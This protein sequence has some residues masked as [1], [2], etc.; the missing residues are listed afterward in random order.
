MPCRVWSEGRY[1]WNVLAPERSLGLARDLLGASTCTGSGRSWRSVGDPATS[2]RTSNRCQDSFCRPKRARVCLRS[3]APR[4]RA[5]LAPDLRIDAVS[6][7]RALFEVYLG[8]NSVVPDARAAW[9]QGARALLAT[10]QARARA[11][12]SLSGK[13]CLNEGVIL[14]TCS[15][16]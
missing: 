3:H 1:A 10:E 13:T 5:Q 12:N 15:D 4:P 14:H 6:L 16:S 2:R 11:L 7:G 8:S 9:A